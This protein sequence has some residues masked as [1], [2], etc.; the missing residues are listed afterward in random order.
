MNNSALPILFELNSRIDKG[1]SNAMDREAGD[2]GAA[3]ELRERELG[4]GQFGD[5]LRDGLGVQFGEVHQLVGQAVEPDDG[6]PP[7]H[8]GY[9]DRHLTG[10]ITILFSAPSLPLLG[11]CGADWNKS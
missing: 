6:L 9:R 4:L 11:P 2:I 5:H 3:G 10:D 1:V 7:A 8:G